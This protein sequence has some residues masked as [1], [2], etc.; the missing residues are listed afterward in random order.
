V[1]SDIIVINIGSKTGIKVG[2]ELSVERVTREIKDPATGQ[3]LR[4]LSTRIAVIELTEVDAASGVGKVV[5]GGN[6][7]KVGDIVK[8]PTA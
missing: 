5:A 6:R 7:I 1:T 8:T 3:V 2:D 4:K